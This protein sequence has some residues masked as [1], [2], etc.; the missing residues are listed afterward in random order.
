MYGHKIDMVEYERSV[1]ENIAAWMMRELRKETQTRLNTV[2][3]I[4]RVLQEL[5]TA[6]HNARLVLYHDGSGHIELTLGGQAA[7]PVVT[8]FRDI[9]N[10]TAEPPSRAGWVFRERV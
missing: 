1:E 3:N 9:T 5:R 2:E 4:L 7:K 10:V 8:S 6:S